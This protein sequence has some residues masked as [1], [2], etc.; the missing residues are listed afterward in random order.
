MCWINRPQDRCTSQKE[1]LRPQILVSSHEKH[2]KC[3][4]R[5][6][7]FMISSHLLLGWMSDYMYVL[8][9]KKSIHILAP[10]PPP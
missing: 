6:V 4:L 1:F 5:Y 10:P 7:F 2:Q 8:A 9:K 3:N